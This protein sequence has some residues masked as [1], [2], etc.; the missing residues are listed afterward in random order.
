MGYGVADTGVDF[1]FL[2]PKEAHALL[3]SDKAVFVDS[4]DPEDFKMSRIQTSY[5]LPANDIMFR[6]QKLDKSLAPKCKELSENGKIV[7]VLS[8]AGISGMQNRGHVSRCRHVAQYLHELGVDKD[9]IR[10]LQGG[11]NAWKIADLDGILGDRRRYYAGVVMSADDTRG[12]ETEMPPMPPMPP[13]DELPSAAL[14]PAVPEAAVAAVNEQVPPA[15]TSPTAYRVLR[16]EVFKKAAPD[17]EKIFK[18]QRA[19]DSIVRTTGGLFI[20]AS[21]GRWAEL[22]VSAGE[23]KGWVYVEGPGLGPCTKKIHMQFLAA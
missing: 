11:L 22:D 5:S 15:V 21:G 16:G 12:A 10:R 7:V 18:L 19:N 23:K 2:A 14:V 20:G 17:A 4:R 6:P 8:D 13:T 9:C 3:K 1:E